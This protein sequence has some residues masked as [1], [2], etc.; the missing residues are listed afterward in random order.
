MATT[1]TTSLSGPIELRTTWATVWRRKTSILAI[2]FTLAMLALCA[3][4][5]SSAT[6]TSGRISTLYWAATALPL[7]G[8]I[9]AWSA[10]WS[11]A[12]R[13]R[14]PAL[15]VDALIRI[16]RT[17]VRYALPELGC[18]QIFNQGGTSYIALLPKHEKGRVPADL[19]S[20]DPYIVEF[21]V[22]ARPQPFEL[23]QELARRVPGLDVDKLGNI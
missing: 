16:P 19:H 17:G 11:W 8:I 2:I 18:A 9:M 14:K 13:V 22:G 12:S 7:L 6:A 10:W 4:F 15:F 21:P 3:I 1:A 20:V 23:G 5:T